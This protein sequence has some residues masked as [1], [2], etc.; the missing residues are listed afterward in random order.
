MQLRNTS[1]EYASRGRKVRVAIVGF[2]TVG[3]CVAKLLT[4]NFAEQ[5]QLTHICN[6]NIERKK[7]DSLPAHIRWTERIEE[8]LTS[9]ADVVVELVGGL[10]PA[11][12]WVRRSLQSG[13][14]V[15]T[16]N[17]QLISEC[18]SQLIELAREKG[19][20]I[21]YGASVGG[22]IPVL[23]GLQEGLAGD[24]LYKIAGIL[25][26]TCNYILS[27]MEATGASFPAALQEAQDLGFAEADPSDDVEGFD[28]R[29]KLV[30]LIRAG[31]HCQ[32]R[33]DQVLC[34]SISSI[35]A[36]DF[37]Y[38]RE[39][40]RTIRQVSLAQKDSP[41]RSRLF[42]V[43]Q[44][45]LIP[46]SSPMAHVQGSQNLIVAVGESVGE[47]VF[48]GYG[49]GGGPTAVAVVSDLLS[50]ARNTGGAS[51]DVLP[52]TE[53]PEEVSGELTLPHYLRL[54]VEDRPGIVAAVASILAKHEIN[55]DALLQK[56]GYPHSRLPFV[57]TLE[58]CGSTVLSRALHE[59]GQ[60]SF[61]VQPPVCLP[62]LAC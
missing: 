54:T 28:A 46:L 41:N 30:I 3:Q 11:G 14:S 59:I 25:N 36:V 40:N 24:R 52:A 18:G 38:A 15:V 39:L 4:Q 29:S 27:R 21:E 31:L 35:E 33:S 42:A 13:K 20:R 60:L 62:I 6:R 50:I 8:V 9:D 44:P 10:Q 47:T 56:P 37:V 48:S 12:D 58:P 7:A 16:A 45:A 2:G 51:G 32:V 1:G 34:R 5:F 49:A 57:I 61:H 22:G 55:I 23:V 26:G 43:V 17:K 19:R 53:L